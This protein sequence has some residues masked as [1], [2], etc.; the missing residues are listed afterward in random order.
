VTLYITV[1]QALL[2]IR[3]ATGAEPEVRDL[4]LLESALA[5][6]AATVLGREAYPEPLTKAA[7]L[8]HSLATNHPLVDG[9]KRLAWLAT[10]VFCAKN[11][12]DLDPTDQA[13][14]DLVIGVASGE[15]DD[16]ED[17]ATVLSSFEG[18]SG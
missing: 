13:A 6:P 3:L 7:A 8:L 14:Y 1:E 17:I 9:N 16:V 5:R 18:R 11:G 4:G 10:W 2:I 12:I 15:L